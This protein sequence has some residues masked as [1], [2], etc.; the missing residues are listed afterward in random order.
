MRGTLTPILSGSVHTGII[1][2][3]AGNTDG[4][5]WPCESDGDHPRVCGE[6]E[7]GSVAARDQWG[8][9][10]RM[11]GT[12]GTNRTRRDFRG[13]IP[14]YAGNTRLEC[15]VLLRKGDHP[16]VCGEHIIRISCRRLQRG[17]SPRM[18]GTRQCITLSSMGDGIIPAYAGN[19]R[20]GPGCWRTAG[21]HPRVCGEHSQ[22]LGHLRCVAGIIPAYAGNTRSASTRWWCPGDHPRVCGEHHSSGVSASRRAGSSPRMRGT[23]F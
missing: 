3:Y 14:A 21:D 2:A 18:R 1:P 11:R 5:P 19:T 6:H 16:R 10:P 7:W 4:C 15:L 22:S 12:H 20:P 23:R 13:I 9:S 17:S 8:S